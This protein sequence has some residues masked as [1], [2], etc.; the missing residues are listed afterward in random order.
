MNTAIKTNEIVSWHGD[1][2]IVKTVALF[3]TGFHIYKQTKP[4]EISIVGDN[5]LSLGFNTYDEAI[6]AL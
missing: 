1:F 6:K 5:P 2:C 3:G 4:T